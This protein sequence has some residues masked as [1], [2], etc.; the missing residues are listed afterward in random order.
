MQ[1]KPFIE[2]YY[3]PD[4]GYDPLLDCYHNT[5]HA[6][7]RHAW[8]T[9]KQGWHLRSPWLSRFDW[10]L[11]AHLEA[12]FRQRDRLFLSKQRQ[13]PR[14]IF[15]RTDLLNVFFRH[16][17]PTIHRPVALYLGNAEIPLSACGVEINKLVR[18]PLIH[19]VFAEN[20][21]LDIDSVTAMPL[22]M[23]PREM[24]Q[25]NSVLDLR[26]IADNV[27]PDQKI[28]KVFG[29]WN[30]KKSLANS[31]NDREMAQQY[32]CGHSEF[33]DYADFLPLQEFWQTM[34]EYR[35]MF[36]PCSHVHDSAKIFE[37]LIVKTIP[38]IMA[39][40]YTQAY[41]GLPVAVI[42]DLNEIT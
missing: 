11:D 10:I 26:Q 28:E 1:D 31:R 5:R 14:T 19:H 38:I 9:D 13:T 42:Q 18:H 34:S 25:A 30:K 22:G 3:T 15:V 21:D 7:Q 32:L 29:A 4:K 16:V 20:K 17:L 40:P 37:A 33:C 8:L 12:D 6:S 35:F 27:N 2:I 24:L 36:A 41:Q 23:H 39:G